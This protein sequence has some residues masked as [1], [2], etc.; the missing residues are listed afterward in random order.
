MQSIPDEFKWN[1]R[2]R[3]EFQRVL[4]VIYKDIHYF[5]TIIYYSK[6][7]KVDDIRDT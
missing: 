3:A 2:A 5:I 1:S 4:P 7:V 6:I